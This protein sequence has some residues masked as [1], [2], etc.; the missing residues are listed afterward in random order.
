L[1]A[2]FSVTDCLKEHNLLFRHGKSLGEG[3]FGEVILVEHKVDGSKYAV[4]KLKI[5]REDVAER[6]TEEAKL[7][8]N[9]LHANICR[10]YNAW[11]ESGCVHIRM[12]LCDTDLAK[13][14]NRR[15]KL[16]FSNSVN[17]SEPCDK[18][19]QCDWVLPDK[20]SNQM[21]F[22]GIK[23]DGTNDFLKGLLKGVKYLHVC[24]EV[25]HQDLHSKNVLLKI[26]ARPTQTAV[27]AKICDFGLASMKNGSSR[28]AAVDDF[29]DDL[30]EIGK[31]LLRL[32]YPLQ[33]GDAIDDLL[34]KL[35]KASISSCEE[36]IKPHFREMWP[37]QASWIMRLL[38]RDGKK[39]S[40][41]EMLDEGMTSRSRSF[42]SSKYDKGLQ[43]G[44]R[45]AEAS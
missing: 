41:A 45:R 20:P 39:P 4:K 18:I 33:G 26:N 35:Q 28:N 27:T 5:D 19:L 12:E 14:I 38:S 13:W 22:S 16:L 21:W 36:L 17:E 34:S 2:C 44:A 43:D 1:F 15:N 10:Y 6:Q 9:M 8:C 25:A 24:R 32:Y 30:R 42:P 7:M 40:A 29:D 11:Q 3:S 37:D 31:I 23:A